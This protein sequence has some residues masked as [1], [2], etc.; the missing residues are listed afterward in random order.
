MAAALGDSLCERYQEPHRHYHHLGHLASSLAELD[1]CGEDLPL[2]EGAIWFHD[3]IYDP[4][5]ADNESASIAWFRNA[6]GSWLTPEAAA[7]ISSLIEATDFRTTPA[8]DPEVRLMID[9]DLA[10]LSAEPDTYDAYR[11]AIRQEYSHVGDEAFLEGR[12]KVM[13]HFMAN[14]IYR[15]A[16]FFSREEQARANISLELARLGSEDALQFL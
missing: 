9:I 12:T 2:I 8:D 1:R 7:A 4:T 10:I 13:G 3:V 16:A 15:T 5:R 6:T 11:H 14:P